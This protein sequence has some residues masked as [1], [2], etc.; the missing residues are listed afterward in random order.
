MRSCHLANQLFFN[1]EITLNSTPR[2]R[3]KTLSTIVSLFHGN[4]ANPNSDDTAKAFRHSL[5]I[6]GRVLRVSV[7]A[8]SQRPPWWLLKRASCV[9]GHRLNFLFSFDTGLKEV[10]FGTLD[11]LF[12]TF[13]KRNMKELNCDLFVLHGPFLLGFCAGFTRAPFDKTF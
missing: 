1:W 11:I 10:Q 2:R 6:D 7:C 13:L 9:C 5:T 4:T 3:E 12:S 8:V